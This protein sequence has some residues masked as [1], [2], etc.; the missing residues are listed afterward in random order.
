MNTLQESKLSMYLGE[1][2]FLNLSAT[3]TATLP[4]F[5]TYFATFTGNITLIQSARQ[6][7]EA[8]K[9][10]V[11]VNKNLL[12]ADL[13]TKAADISRRVAAY[14]T[15]VNNQ[16]LLAEVNYPESELNHSPDTILHDRC[17]LIWDRGNTNVAAL[18]TYGVTAAMLTALQTAITA[19]DAAIPQPTVGNSGD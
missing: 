9:T 17:K 5:A 15:V 14:A 10:G 12:R 7:Q 8:D 11:T 3:I 4:N 13:V 6:T 19:F 1:Q 2:T 16:K 18:A